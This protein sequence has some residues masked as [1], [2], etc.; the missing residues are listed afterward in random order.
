MGYHVK[1]IPL[2]DLM[3]QL[4]WL[5]V[6]T[7]VYVISLGLSKLSILAQYLRIFVTVR[8]VRAIWACIIFVIAYTL[9]SLIVGIFSCNP[10]RKFWDP[11]LQEGSCI[12]YTLYYY[13]AAAL[14][15]LTDL[16][17]ILV[18]VPALRHLNVSRTKRIGVM[19]LFSVGGFGCIVSIIRLWTLYSLDLA[20]RRGDSTYANASPALWSSI[21]IHVCII[22]ACLPSLSPMLSLLLRSIGLNLSSFSHGGDAGRKSS[23]YSDRGNARG[24]RGGR[25]AKTYLGRR[26][27]GSAFSELPS[28]SEGTGIGTEETNIWGE[29]GFLAGRDVEKAVELKEVNGREY[30]NQERVWARTGELGTSDSARHA[31]ILEWDPRL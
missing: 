3:R 31:M 28:T 8:T 13:V 27:S 29:V 18:P 15:I 2:P 4:Q 30:G 12:N 11:T 17:I 14:N 9:Q 5:W 16:A 1:D 26:K 10:P 22:C 25:G 24:E 7:W 21:E 19:L 20:V 6:S 23:G